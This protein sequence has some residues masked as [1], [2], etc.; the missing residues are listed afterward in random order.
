MNNRASTFSIFLSNIRG[1]KS[2]KVSL[3]KIVKKVRPS[4]VLLNETQLVNNMKISLNTYT[5]WTKNR[6][7]K[8]GGGISTSVSQQFSDLA[9]GAGEGDRDDEFLITR[10]EAFS[11]ALCVINSYGEQR[12][13][14]KEEVEEKWGRL[15]KELEDIRRRGEFCVWAGDQ[16]KLVGAGELGVPGNSPETSLGGRLLRELLAS[17]N[18][19]LVNGL[20]AE[21][22]EGGPHTRKDPAT[23]KKSCLDLFVVSREL[24]PFV[25]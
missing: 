9:V 21:I 22:V 2:K 12:I 15:L 14:K 24:L 13:T 23:G 19:I 8:G 5:T 10:V 17:G 3:Q 20:G 4:L 7:D 18:W 11:P 16:N 1:Y 25:K 6:T